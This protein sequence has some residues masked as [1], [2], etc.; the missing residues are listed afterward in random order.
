MS[1]CNYQLWLFLQ[2]SKRL[3]KGVKPF[4]SKHENKISA[5]DT[6][7]LGH[8]DVY[9]T[10]P[11][12]NLFIVFFIFF[13]KF[14]GEVTFSLHNFYVSKEAGFLKKVSFLKRGIIYKNIN[15]GLFVY[16]HKC[17]NPHKKEPTNL[18]KKRFT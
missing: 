6:I 10:Y 12:S 13:L 9:V 7:K 4:L 5:N 1:K 15:F 16:F 8:S 2:T 18:Q 11:P 14:R 17:T 3:F